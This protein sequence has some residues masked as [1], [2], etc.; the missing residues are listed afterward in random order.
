MRSGLCMFCGGGPLTGEHVFPKWMSEVLTRHPK[1]F[2]ETFKLAH[3]EDHKTQRIIES[4]REFALSARCVCGPCNGGWMSTLE[5]DAKRYLEPMILGKKTTL[6]L[7]AQDTISA[8]IALKIM[9]GIRAHPSRFDVFPEWIQSLYE[10]E[11]VPAGW[12]VWA[13]A[14]NGVLTNGFESGSVGEHPSE[15]EPREG[16]GVIHTGIIST[17]FAGYC[18]LKVA[19]LRR[20]R[21]PNPSA[22]VLL[23]LTPSPGVPL[24]WPPRKAFTDATIGSL[25]DMWRRSGSSRIVDL[26]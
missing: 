10:A 1:G 12:R 17:F 13:G 19:G 5:A 24:Q 14:Y 7:V 4:E 3:G 15:V 25:F 8:W 2:P 16:G 22:D 11:T 18:V 23:P 21:L 20:Y 6:D 26:I 9:V